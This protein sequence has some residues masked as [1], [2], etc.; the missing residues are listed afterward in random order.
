MRSHTHT[1]AQASRLF[2]IYSITV[3]PSVEVIFCL[4]LPIVVEFHSLLSL[5]RAHES[6]LNVHQ[7][8]TIDQCVPN[9]PVSH[10]SHVSRNCTHE[11]EHDLSILSSFILFLYPDSAFFL[12]SQNYVSIWMCLSRSAFRR[13]T[14]T[15]AYV[16]VERLKCIYVE[17]CFVNQVAYLYD[18]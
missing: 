15:S 7:K 18:N 17:S 8:W 1:R 6:W 13:K 16:Y 2:G 10:V 3:H 14:G 5:T 11:P 12:I 9:P 4:A